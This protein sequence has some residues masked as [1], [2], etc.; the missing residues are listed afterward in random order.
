MSAWNCA[1]LCSMCVRLRKEMKMKMKMVYMLH[2]CRGCINV[3]F[4]LLQYGQI[5]AASDVIL[6]IILFTLFILSL[7][8]FCYF[9][10]YVHQT[11]VRTG[12]STF[13]EYMYFFLSK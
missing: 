12:R 10:R 3:F 1:S 8:S 6:L 11:C 7:I 5:F 2:L 13:Q 4:F 9:I